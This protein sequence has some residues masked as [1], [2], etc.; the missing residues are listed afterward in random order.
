MKIWSRPDVSD[1]NATQLPSGENV[2]K[3]SI[4]GETTNGS[5]VPSS[6]E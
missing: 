5:V 3:L 1:E 4:P 2:G 6:T